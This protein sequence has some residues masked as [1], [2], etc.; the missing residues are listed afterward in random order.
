MNVLTIQNLC[1]YL[2]QLGII[3]QKSISPF[4]SLYSK[5]INKNG[6]EYD[7]DNNNFINIS[8]FENV[9]CSYLKKIFEVKK[10]FKIFSHKIIEK[11]KQNILKN[12]YK[13]IFIL[14]L[15]LSKR[16][17]IYFMDFYCKLKQYNCK[18]RKSKPIYVKKNCSYKK[19]DEDNIEKNNENE[20]ENLENFVVMN[21]KNKHINNLFLN[22]Y[23]FANKNDNFNYNKISKPKRSSYNIENEK[24]YFN[25]DYDNYNKKNS[26]ANEMIN[27]KK[28]QMTSNFRNETKFNNFTKKSKSL[29]NSIEYTKKIVIYR[30]NNCDNKN[31]NLKKKNSNYNNFQFENKKNIFLSRIKKEH[32]INFKKRENINNLNISRNYTLKTKENKNI[33][34]IE[35]NNNSLRNNNEYSYNQNA[36]SKPNISIEQNNIPSTSKRNGYLNPYNS[37][38]NYVSMMDIYKHNKSKFSLGK[39]PNNS[40]KYKHNNFLSDD[41]NTFN[42]NEFS[43]INN[44]GKNG[45]LVFNQNYIGIRNLKHKFKYNLRNNTE[46]IFNKNFVDNKMEIHSLSSNESSF[47]DNE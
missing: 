16:I 17:K 7:D 47:I 42:T 24:Q 32:S 28:N 4:L 44:T 41:N 46:E 27:Y 37:Y 10:N 22:Y 1:T 23:K 31:I 6:I 18:N 9:L 5:A 45:N 36:N 25:T 21:P 33:N 15:I 19:I 29:N 40:V 38:H 12:K 43:S 2:E 30:K 11:F 14:F 26:K 39:Q 34:Y 13:C 3:D 20:Y 8:I 35:Y